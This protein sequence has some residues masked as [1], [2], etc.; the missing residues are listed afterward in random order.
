LSLRTIP[1]FDSKLGSWEA[2]CMK[3]TLDL[4]NEL[5]REIKLKAAHEGRKIKDVA[6]DL[7]ASGMVAESAKNKTARSRKGILKLPLFRCAKDAPVRRMNIEE[8]LALEQATLN[9]E[10]FERLGL[11]L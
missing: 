1:P 11:S 5:V 10:D 4:P 2:G 8:I 9:Q 3:T 6:A 7:I